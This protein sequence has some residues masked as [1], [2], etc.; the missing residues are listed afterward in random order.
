MRRTAMCALLIHDDCKLAEFLVFHMARNKNKRMGVMGRHTST[1]KLRTQPSSMQPKRM[2]DIERSLYY[3][4][5]HTDLLSMYCPCTCTA[6]TRVA[7]DT[8]LPSCSA[9]VVETLC[10]SFS[11]L[12]FSTYAQG[13]KSSST[14]KRRTCRHLLRLFYATLR[15]LRH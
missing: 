14:V 1:L 9:D 3:T 2:T 4:H 12:Y 11:M 6:V 8:R 13:S 15:L 7:R 10:S 5:T